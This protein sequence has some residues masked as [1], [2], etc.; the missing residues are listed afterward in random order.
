[1]ARTIPTRVGRTMWAGE[2]GVMTMDHPHAGGE[3]AV[4]GLMDAANEGP[5]PRGWEER[6]HISFG[7]VGFG[8]IPTRVG[9]TAC[10]TVRSAAVADHPHAGG[11]NADAGLARLSLSGPSPRGWGEPLARDVRLYVVR[12]I[13]TR[14]GRT[15]SVH[16]PRFGSR[17][18]P[19][20]GGEN[21]R[22]STVG[23]SVGGP[24]PRGWGE[25]LKSGVSRNA[26]R[27]IPTRVGRTA[28]PIAPPTGPPDHPHAGG[29]NG[30]EWARGWNRV[31][32]SP[33]GWGERAL[34][35]GRTGRA[36]TIPTRVGRTLRCPGAS[37][38]RADHPHAGGENPVNR[39]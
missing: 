1:M 5:S 31:G 20:A 29:E 33:R 14:V 18:H 38:R 7:L 22:A 15:R 12:T 24:S 16:G 27:T 21:P 17:D 4:S 23:G 30:L 11:E 19:H 8:T 10:Y 9:R 2:S 34:P 26:R 39:R 13:P 6:F 36:R 37:I 25:P 3:N 32:P 35:A 28:R